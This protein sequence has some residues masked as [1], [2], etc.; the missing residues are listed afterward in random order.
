MDATTG[1]QLWGEVLEDVR[2]IPRA[3]Q[4]QHRPAQAT[5]IEDLDLNAIS[6]INQPRLWF[7]R[8]CGTY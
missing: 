6:D 8:C 4:K 7:I 5:P 3:R 1:D 2:R